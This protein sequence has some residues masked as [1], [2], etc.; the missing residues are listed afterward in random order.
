MRGFEQGTVKSQTVFKSNPKE[1]TLR[2]GVVVR[3]RVALTA[4]LHQET[5]VVP[6]HADNAVRLMQQN[7]CQHAPMAVHHYHLS[8]CSTKQHLKQKQQGV[9]RERSNDRLKFIKK[10]IT[11]TLRQENKDEN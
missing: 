11:W 7:M 10:K 1:Q 2:W 9:I 6:G 3:V 4:V 5:G 8:I